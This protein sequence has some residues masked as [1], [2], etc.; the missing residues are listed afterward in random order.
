[1]EQ[2]LRLWGRV[3]TITPGHL[4]H[5]AH[6]LLCSCMYGSVRS[7]FCLR[8]NWPL[9]RIWEFMA[10]FFHLQWFILFLLSLISKPSQTKGPL[11]QWVSRTIMEEDFLC[12][13]NPKEE[14]EETERWK[15]CRILRDAVCSCLLFET[16]KKPPSACL[17][18]ED[19]F[20]WDRGLAADGSWG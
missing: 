19:L 2:P 8:I 20:V 12:V 11:I 13:P 18:V 10:F 6:S 7:H 9:P 14:L 15:K 17:G 1:M 4:G 3:N 5:R 16:W